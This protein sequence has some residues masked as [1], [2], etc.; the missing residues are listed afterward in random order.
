MEQSTAL[1]PWPFFNSPK[2]PYILY[3]SNLFKSHVSWTYI[4]NW[5]LL[6]VHAEPFNIHGI[7]ALFA[8]AQRVEDGCF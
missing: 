6:G 1:R 3:K 2:N 5:Q 8:S 7:P 4:E